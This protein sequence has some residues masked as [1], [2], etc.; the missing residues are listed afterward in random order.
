MQRYYL[1][2]GI[3][4]NYNVIINGENSYDQLID[5][6]KKSYKENRKLETK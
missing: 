5:C 6:G 4:D 3:I 2:K 1:P